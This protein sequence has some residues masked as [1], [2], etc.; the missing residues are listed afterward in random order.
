MTI[1]IPSKN[2]GNNL[3]H[4]ISSISSQIMGQGL[5]VIIADISDEQ[6][7]LDIIS[8]I[9]ID[10]KYSLNIEVIKGGYPAYGRYMGAKLATTPYILFLDADIILFDKRVL[11]NTLSK[12]DNLTTVTFITDYGYNWIYKLFT[13]TQRLMKYF[14][15]SFAIGGFQL[16]NTEIYKKVGEYNPKHVFAED[17][18]VSN[19]IFSS[20][21]TIHK[22]KGVYTSARRFVN[23][24]L[25]YMIILMLKC[26]FNRNNEEFYLKSHGYWD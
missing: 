19:K 17:Y 23:K 21:F 10:F 26:W 22:T 7:S 5:R 12:T 11:Q 13:S 14:G 18:Y 24:G 1:I 9:Q 16:F 15:S 25:F 20:T 4:T 6:K 2:E 8:Q 3:Y